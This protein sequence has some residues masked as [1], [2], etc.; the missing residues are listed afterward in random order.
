L[1]LPFA[2]FPTEEAARHSWR[3][4]T[5][6]HNREGLALL[7]GEPALIV[8]ACRAPEPSQLKPAGCAVHAL[9]AADKDIVAGLEVLADA[10]G[11][12]KRNYCSRPDP[13]WGAQRPTQSKSIAHALAAALPENSILIGESLTTGRET[14]G[15]TAG[16]TP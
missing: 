16:A 12:T 1:V 3:H 6:N 8:L 2:S 11:R 13:I 14:L 5:Y 7:P 10:G 4:E 15:I 9:V